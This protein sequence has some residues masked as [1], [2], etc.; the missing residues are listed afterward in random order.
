MTPKSC[1]LPVLEQNKTP[2]TQAVKKK[3]IHPEKEKII[4]RKN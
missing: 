4:N 1:Y 3:K 2:K